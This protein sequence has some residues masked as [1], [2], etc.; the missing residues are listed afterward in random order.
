MKVLLSSLLLLV[1]AFASGPLPAQAQGRAWIHVPDTS[2]EFPVNV[3]KHAH[4]N[5]LIR[6][7]PNGGLGPNGGMT[8]AQLRSFYNMPSVGGSGVIAIVDAYHYPTA[9][10]DFNVFSAQ[11]NLPIETSNN[12]TASTNTVF[13]VVYASGRKPRTN[14]G[15]A[16]EAALDIEWAH[17]M[18]PNAKIVL[19]EAASNSFA[20]LF[21][22]VDKASKLPGVTQVSMSWGGSEF[23]SEA[24]YDTHF[25]KSGVVYF[26]SSGDV[27]GIVSYP[28]VSPYVVAVGGTSVSTNSS[29]AFVNET[30]WNGSGGGTSRY[31][32]KPAYQI[33]LSGTKRRVPDISSDADPYTGVAVYDST[34]YQGFAGWLVFGGTSVS[35]PCM[36]GMVNLAGHTAGPWSSSDEL[37]RIYSALGTSS[38]RDILSGKAG[39]FNAVSGWDFVTGVGAPLGLGGI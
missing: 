7:V 35:S 15:W 6:I 10:N 33:S 20:S 37:N 17:A 24:V 26:A 22:A 23:S 38:F 30:G 29:G 32:A 2:V 27:G 28:A 18:A 36:A 34:S 1:T 11:F 25:Q 21:A 4:T 19:V 3:G 14:A 16:Q 12:A 5:H 13:Q 8:P 39:N 31:E 9:L